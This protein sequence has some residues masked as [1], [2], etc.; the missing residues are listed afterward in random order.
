MEPDL[1]RPGNLR[2]CHMEQG[3]YRCNGRFNGAGPGKARKFVTPAF[4]LTHVRVEHGASMEPDLGRPGNLF[5]SIA[6]DSLVSVKL[7]QWSRTWEGPEISG[8]S[9]AS[10]GTGGLTDGFNG[11]GPGKARK[12]STRDGAMVLSAPDGASMEPDL[13]RPGNRHKRNWL[14][15]HL[16]LPWSRTWEGPEIQWTAGP[17]HSTRPASMRPDLGRPVKWLRCRMF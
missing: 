17:G 15:C 11:A 16:T 9:S 12:Y 13:G 1:G 10:D 6:E 3:R 2:A 4:G 7:L 5:C 14:F 8:T